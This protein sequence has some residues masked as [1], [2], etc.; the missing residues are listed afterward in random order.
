MYLPEINI[1]PLANT[2]KLPTITINS[3]K[4]ISLKKILTTLTIILNLKNPTNQKIS[5]LK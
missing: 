2:L 4:K 1:R 3:S 5:Q